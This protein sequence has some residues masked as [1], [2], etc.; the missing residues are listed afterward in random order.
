MDKRLR[1]ESTRRS[2]LKAAG[3]LLPAS[4]IAPG[5]LH[6]Q[7]SQAA[8]APLPTRTLGRT[9]E[10]LSALTL[11]AGHFR[12]QF[13]D[14]ARVNAIVERALELGVNSIDTAPNYQES[15]AFLGEALK[16]KRDKVFLAGKSE[17]P[18]YDGC[19]RQ[20]E[21]SLKDLQ[22]DRIDLMY[23]HNFGLESRFPN[24]EETLGPKGTLGA[25]LDAKKQ[26]VVRYIGVSGHVYPSR[27]KAVLE[28]DDIDVY[29]CT[30]N[31][32][33][34]YQYDFESKIFTPGRKKNIG[35]I[36]MKVLGGPAD[37]NKGTARFTGKQLELAIRYAL[38]LPGVCSA[39]IGVR[40]VEELEEVARCVAEYKPL[41]W[42]ESAALNEESKQLAKS[43]GPLYGTPLT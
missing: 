4:L 28:R 33:A 31:P 35:L 41:S 38:D 7:Q 8:E 39:N 23:V 2:V 1:E 25:L 15:E 18:T 5:L 24:I 43:W 3:A 16:G 20:I 30:V 13:M 22:T 21:K 29:L 11:G 36:A 26:G 37:W 6:T 14:G 27:W 19:K 34:R 9:N 17:E 40:T 42:E 32:V 12:A 10:W